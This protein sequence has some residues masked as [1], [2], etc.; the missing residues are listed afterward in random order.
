M[1]WCYTVEKA[2]DPVPV[3][4]T[5]PV[6]PEDPPVDP[7]DNNDTTTPANLILCVD[8][9]CFTVIEL[10][11][12]EAVN[13]ISTI[14]FVKKQA[15][16]PLDLAETT[17]ESDVQASFDETVICLEG[18]LKC[19]TPID[20][21][22]R[23]GDPTVDPEKVKCF[24]TWCYL[25]DE[26][27]KSGDNTHENTDNNETVPDDN[28]THAEDNETHTDS[29]TLCFD[30]KHCFNI[31]EIEES[32][33]FSTNGTILNFN[34]KFYTPLDRA[35]NVTVPAYGVLSETVI[36]LKGDLECYIPIEIV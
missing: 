15:Y 31:L 14:F 34:D 29:L 16:Q 26:P 1:G 19:Y 4:P 18:D 30:E 17:T 27:Y 24:K 5:D 12:T 28:E 20:L 33:A 22:G 8:T 21:T 36:C 3:E 25:V 32:E 2:Y 10:S 11:D 23:D 7:A 13:S 6:N 35:V 9:N